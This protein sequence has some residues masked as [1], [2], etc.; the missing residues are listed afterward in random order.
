MM[1][2]QNNTF[3]L[4]RIW[5]LAK[6]DVGTNWKVYAWR[7]FGLYLGYLALM[8]FNYVAVGDSADPENIS[9]IAFFTTIVFMILFFRQASLVMERM[10]TKGGRT[11]FL[12]LP[13]SNLEKFVWRAIFMSVFFVV[14]G[15][16]TFALADLTRYLVLFVCGQG[17]APFIFSHYFLSWLGYVLFD[18]SVFAI[19]G[20]DFWWDESIRAFGAHFIFSLFLL[21]GCAWR[22]WAGLKVLVGVLLIYWGIPELLEHFAPKG[23]SAIY[24]HAEWVDGMF[25]VLT[26]LCWWLAYRLFRRSQI[27]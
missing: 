26:I 21:G 4:S 11:T 27:V 18:K 8:M 6:W 19:Q 7:Y 16:V 13:A 22:Q 14:M 25:L 20:V 17:D 5:M 23:L 9:S 10:L 1:M 15:F 3:S 12:T 2:K 24:F